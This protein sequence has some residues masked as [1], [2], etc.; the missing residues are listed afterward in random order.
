VA[1]IGSTDLMQETAHHT[2][3]VLSGRVEAFIDAWEHTAEPPSPR[4][5]LPDGPPAVRCLT[6]VELLKVDLEYRWIHRKTPRTIEEYFQDFTELAHGFPADL[7]YEECHI[8]RRAGDPVAP[9]DYLIRFPQR[10][11]ELRRLF[12]L[13]PADHSTSL[14]RGIGPQLANIQPGERLD[15]FDLLVLLGKGAFASVFLARQNSMQRLV[16]LKVSADKGNEPQTL[17]QLDHEHIVRVFDQRLLP[18]RKLRLLYMQYVPGGTLQG[19]VEIVRRTPPAERT[20]MML[21]AGIEEALA[22]RGE[23]LPV[24]SGLKAR[25]A[26]R[27][28]PDVVCGLGAKLARALD[29]A[30]RHGVLHR[31]IKPANVLVT[32][33]G[34]PRLADFNIGFSSKVAGAT[35]AAY[36]GGTVAYMSPEQLEACNPA[37]DREPDSLDG[38]SDLYSLVVVL[39]ELLTGSR[40]FTDDQ[41]AGGWGTTLAEMTARRRAGV[42][43]ELAASVSRD[44]PPGLCDVLLACLDP[45]IEKRPATGNELARQLELCLAPKAHTLLAPPRQSWRRLVRRLPVTCVVVGTVLPNAFAAVFNYYY[46]RSEIIQNLPNSRQA[47][48]QTQAVIN[49]IAFPVGILLLI[50]FTRPVGTA[51]A[52][53]RKGN[54]LPV[55]AL[56]LLRR[57]C[58]RLGHVAAAISLT[59]WLVAA[60]AYP[61]ALQ[62]EVGSIPL[63]A[64]VHFIASLSLCGLI[65]AAYPYFVVACLSVCSY[66]PAL[67][68]FETMTDED[69]GPLVRLARISGLY[70]L[71]AATVPMLSVAVLVLVGSQARFALGLLA[72]AGLAGF[73]LAFLGYRMLQSDLDALTVIA[74]PPGDAGD[75]PSVLARS[76]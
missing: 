16:A 46:N 55:D 38:R 47:F 19:V 57:R 61:V 11:A 28:W 43:R 66:Y 68:R 64:Y 63:S 30:H 3:T 1:E 33:D 5:F 35:P 12:G 69:R 13:N 44:W 48:E 56:P 50:W 65:A 42:D 45:D 21:V 70:L 40:P 27:P 74:A 20:G 22:R 36:F 75:P 51:V 62:M 8:R 17:A 60:P 32:A 39:W 72:A 2:W 26:H 9:E 18:D 41:L 31:D 73:A 37:H 67:V 14:C 49:T 34:S 10:A 59:L 52:G 25:L 54:P 6:L 71:L 58:L 76:F 53:A 24:Q 7:I 29:H 23:T 15:E 4:D